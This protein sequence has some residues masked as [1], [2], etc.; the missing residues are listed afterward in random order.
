MM[1]YK[2]GL[3]FNFSHQMP[4]FADFFS[5]TML[6]TP[7]EMFDNINLAPIDLMLEND[8]LGDCWEAGTIKQAIL[9]KV[10]A[11]APPPRF[12]NADATRFYSQVTGYNPLKKGS[13]QGTDMIQGGNY[14]L[15][16][17]VIDANGIA[18]KIDAMVA[19]QP[20]NVTEFKLATWLCGSCGM[21]IMV[22]NR[23]EEQFE[24]K[25]VWNFDANDKPDGGHYVPGMG[26]PAPNQISFPTWGGKALMS[27][28]FYERRC[29]QA[30]AYLSF[31]MLDAKGLSRQQFNKDQLLEYLNAMPKG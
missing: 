11:G 9:N 24:A 21:G 22:G 16:N 13:D 30:V 18:H 27:Y 23:Q 15:K 7:P 4:W 6:P 10:L 20:G 17:G 19:I 29:M 8:V 1:K 25:E 26:F 3:S 12:T 5:A 31:E 28:K 14:W 2:T